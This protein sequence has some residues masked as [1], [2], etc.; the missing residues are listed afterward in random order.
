MVDPRMMC[1]QHLLGE[2]YELHKFLGAWKKKKNLSGYYLNGLVDPRRLKARHDELVTEMERRNMSGHKS[3]MKQIKVS[4]KIPLVFISPE[5][6]L[7]ELTER[8]VRCHIRSVELR[9]S[10]M[11]T[12]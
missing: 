7:N 6:N 1:R 11:L 9:S 8:C 2:H 10:N 4:N 5:R 3:P 12:D